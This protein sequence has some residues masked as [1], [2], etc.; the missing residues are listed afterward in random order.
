[1]RLKMNDTNN[2]QCIPVYDTFIEKAKKTTS[3]LTVDEMKEMIHNIN[4]INNNNDKAAIELLYVIIRTH[5]IRH[6]NNIFGVPYKGEKS[7][8]TIVK[9]LNDYKFDIK[10]FPVEL[11]RCILLFTRRHMKNL[12]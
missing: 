6:E 12:S 1:M 3:K 11:Q 9:G 7:D 2:F 8:S 10:N 4:T 5:S